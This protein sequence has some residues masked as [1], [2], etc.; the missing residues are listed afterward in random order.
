MMMRG[1]C[2]DRSHEGRTGSRER[3]RGEAGDE[4]GRKAMKGG[5]GKRVMMRRLR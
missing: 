4:M 3:E 2:D 1:T 5:E